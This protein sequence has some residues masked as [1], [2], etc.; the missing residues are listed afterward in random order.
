MDPTFQPLMLSAGW[1]R[2]LMPIVL[3]GRYTGLLL[4][5]AHLS[6]DYGGN[7][8]G[9]IAHANDPYL[10]IG[11]V[12]IILWL[13]AIAG[14]LLIRTPTARLLLFCL[15]CLAA[16]YGMVGNIII[17]IGTN[18]AERLMYLPSAF[19]V[20]IIAL[21]LCKLPRLP[22]I[23]I[24]TALLLLAAVQTVTAARLWNH[25]VELYESSLVS[26]PESIQAH[27][28]LAEE[29]QMEKNYPAAAKVLEDA[30]DRYQ[31]YWRVWQ[32]RCENDMLAGDFVDAEKSLK[33]AIELDHNPVT[34]DLAGRLTKAEAA[35]RP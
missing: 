31:N 5:P 21:L 25:P 3:L 7:V 1:D 24:T 11:I 14:C 35:T 28:L 22:R 17:L 10:W 30:C 8:I 6:L 27:L 33:R 15:L 34:A 2:I 4:W 16:T 13:I 18:F 29:R 12:T 32:F 26:Q 19:F 9:H 23:A 20:M